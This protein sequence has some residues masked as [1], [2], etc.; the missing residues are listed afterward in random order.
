[1]DK[2]RK[3]CYTVEREKQER[4]RRERQ[5]VFLAR[6]AKKVMKIRKSEKSKT[7]AG[8]TLKSDQ[9]IFFIRVAPTG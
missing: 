6:E 9:H 5:T 8:R 7:L 4:K 3:G 2:A 1:M